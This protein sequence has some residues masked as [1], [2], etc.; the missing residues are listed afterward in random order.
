MFI[1]APGDALYGAD[2]LHATCHDSWRC[3]HNSLFILVTPASLTDDLP[4]P[5]FLAGA[6]NITVREGDTAV[7]PCAVR[8]LGTKQVSWRRID[9]DDFLTIGSMTWVDDEK[10]AVD[11]TRKA[12]DVTI[13]DL[14]IDKVGPEHAGIYECQV[15][16]SLGH[17][18]RVKLNLF[19]LTGK[20]YID[21]YKHQRMQIVKNQSIRDRA[22][23]S[24]LLI[25]RATLRDAGEYVCRSSRN[26][27]VNMKITVLRG[28][29][30]GPT[31]TT[32]DEEHFDLPGISLGNK[33]QL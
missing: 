22:F 13:W 5:K 9:D 3:C 30:P 10:I 24:E 12:Q 26:N 2:I 33:G 16:S 31:Q 7:L 4:P 14:V 18:K 20:R 28:K 17:N 27:I 19:S 21:P 25:S 8:H 11:H 23:V 1:M 6:E 29:P 15:S 32:N